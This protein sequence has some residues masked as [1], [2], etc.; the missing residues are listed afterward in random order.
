MDYSGY[1]NTALRKVAP[2]G[3]NFDRV[4]GEG[5]LRADHVAGLFSANQIEARSP[6]P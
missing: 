2:P 5:T 6:K 3:R 4:G 1:Y